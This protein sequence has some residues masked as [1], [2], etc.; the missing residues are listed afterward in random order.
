MRRPTSPRAVS[1]TASTACQPKSNVQS[2][3]I[4]SEI[5]VGDQL[6]P[7][8][9]V[10]QPGTRVD[11]PQHSPRGDHVDGVRGGQVHDAR[12]VGVERRHQEAHQVVQVQ[13]PHRLRRNL[14]AQQRGHGPA[15]HPIELA[16]DRRRN[17]DDQAG[18]PAAGD[19]RLG[20]PIQVGLARRLRDE[21]QPGTG[22]RGR[23]RHV[24]DPVEVSAA[25]CGGVDRGQ[26][27]DRVGVLGQLLQNGIAQRCAYKLNSGVQTDVRTLGNAADRV[28][29]SDQLP[30]NQPPRSAG[31]VGYQDPH[32]V[33]SA[34]ST[35]PQPASTQPHL[36]QRPF[37]Q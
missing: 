33:T 30:C 24:C 7:A 4:R 3:C 20:R 12:S 26:M 2:S 27:D 31:G 18:P 36:P 23:V 15:H 16:T 35:Q 5:H 25:R 8:A 28:P 29:G 37:R 22:A 10:M 14:G 6:R 34:A 11:G 21:Q 1:A 32:S 17:P 19:E 9:N 13:H